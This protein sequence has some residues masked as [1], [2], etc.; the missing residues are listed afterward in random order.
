MWSKAWKIVFALLAFLGALFFLLICTVVTL[1]LVDTREHTNQEDQPETT[2]QLQ[3][4]VRNCGFGNGEIANIDRRHQ[5]SYDNAG[6]GNAFFGVSAYSLKL[7]KLDS[8][9]IS[10]LDTNDKS[11]WNRP[12][13]NRLPYL[14]QS[15]LQ[16][17]S[18]YVNQTKAP[19]WLPDETQLASSHYYFRASRLSFEDGKITSANICI[20]RPADNRLFVVDL[21]HW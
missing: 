9:E 19:E 7:S 15:A 14:S 11:G 10:T 3:Y 6:D 5:T 20:F 2:S 18:A 16:L 13:R 4:L 12:G 8:N 17:Y 1:V 21:N